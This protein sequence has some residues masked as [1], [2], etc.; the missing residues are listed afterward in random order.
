MQK[1]TPTDRRSGADRRQS[2]AQP[3]AQIERRQTIEPR[4]PEVVEIEISPEQLIALG[5]EAPPKHPS[6]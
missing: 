6:N 5:F 3:P 2:D 1:R 4:Q